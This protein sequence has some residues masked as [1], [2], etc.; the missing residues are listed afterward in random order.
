MRKNESN[1]DQEAGRALMVQHFISHDEQT[2]HANH[3]CVTVTALTL[4]VKLDI[5]M[6]TGLQTTSLDSRSLK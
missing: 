1:R 2:A 3:D 6:S 4:N 5:M